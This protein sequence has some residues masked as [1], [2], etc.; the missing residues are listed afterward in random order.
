MIAAGRRDEAKEQLEM[1]L[2]FYRSVDATQRIAEA[3]ILLAAGA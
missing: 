1:A 2:Q 3:E